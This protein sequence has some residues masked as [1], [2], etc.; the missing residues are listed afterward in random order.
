MVGATLVSP[1][2]VSTT[3]YTEEYEGKAHLTL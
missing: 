2:F 1:Y 3:E